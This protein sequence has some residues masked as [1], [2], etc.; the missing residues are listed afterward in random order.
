[1]LSA[2][3]LLSLIL[4]VY[5]LQEDGLFWP[6][7]MDWV[8]LAI[9]S[10]LCTTLAYALALRPLKVISAFAAN[11]TV[12][13]EPVYGILLAIVLLKEH[14]ELSG[15][16]YLGVVVITVLVLGYPVLKYWKSQRR[17]NQ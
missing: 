15:N 14:K 5:Y 4:P 2:T 3:V 1:M 13:M 10:L 9:L 6:S 11:L 16:F 12:N 17:I 7:K 8:Y